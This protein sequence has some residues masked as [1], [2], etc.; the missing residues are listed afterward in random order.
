MRQSLRFPV[1]ACLATLLLVGTGFAGITNTYSG[2]DSGSGSTATNTNSDAAALA[3]DTAT[4]SLPIVTFESAPLGAFSS[5]VVAPGV[6]LT[7]SDFS[8]SNQSIINT[9]LCTNALCGYNITP[10][11]SQWADAFGGTLTFTFS[12]PISAFGAYFTG[13]QIG[14]ISLSFFDGSSQSIAI[15]NGGSGGTAFVGFTDSSA[16]ISSVTVNALND[17]I[18]VDDVRYGGGTSVPEPGSILLLRSGLLGAAGMLRRKLMRQFQ[19]VSASIAQGRSHGIPAF[20][21]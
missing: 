19:P 15:P 13:V 11:G 4:G 3:F 14:G 2:F 12:T 20:A 16:S 17:I 9:T 8:S 21:V 5:L 10:A 6:T 7:G 1:L 18:G